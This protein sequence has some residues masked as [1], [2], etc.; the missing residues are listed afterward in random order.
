MSQFQDHLRGALE[1][2]FPHALIQENVSIAWE[3]QQLYVDFVLP[4]LGLAFESDGAQHE[5]YSE[6]YHGSTTAFRRAKRR[7]AQKDEWAAA[8]PYVLIRI[9]WKDRER[10]SPTYLLSRVKEAMYGQEKGKGQ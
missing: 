10:L 6:F 1:A 2:C 7:D 5:T 3:G 8:S 4:H 9:P